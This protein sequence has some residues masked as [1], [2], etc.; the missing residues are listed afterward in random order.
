MFDL[1][2]LERWTYLAT[3]VVIIGG[4]LVFIV[5]FH[6]P[7]LWRQGRAL[8]LTT[9]LVTLYGAVLD[10]LAIANGWG[11]FNPA[12]TS[13]IWFGSLL[14]EELIFWVG[15]AFVTGAAALVM[16]AAVDHGIPW[17][18][19]PWALFFPSWLWLNLPASRWD[20]VHR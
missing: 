11:W 2:V 1:S 20:E 18:A 14:F 9:V 12:L 4:A 10:A 6:F 16:A 5:A 3:E 7:V 17:W 13:G 8:A 19:L 15:T